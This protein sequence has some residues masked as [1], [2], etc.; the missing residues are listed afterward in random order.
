LMKPKATEEGKV[1]SE[2]SHGGEGPMQRLGLRS[3]TGKRIDYAEG[4]E[5]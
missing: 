2:V 1:G 4:Q 5:L 3:V